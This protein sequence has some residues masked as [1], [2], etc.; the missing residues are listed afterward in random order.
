[1]G[2]ID[3]LPTQKKKLLILIAFC[4][5]FSIS[6]A[7]TLNR[8]DEIYFQSD[9]FARWYAASH[10]FQEGRNLYDFKNG[11]EVVQSKVRQTT[12]LEAAFYYPAYLALLLWPLTLLPFPTA[13]LLWTIAIG[14]FYFLGILI[15]ARSVEW[16]ANINR[17]T[18][19]ML[20]C[21]LFIPYLQ[22][23]IWSQFDTISIMFLALIFLALLREKYF[24]AGITAGGLL[25]K[26]QTM[27]LTLVFLLVWSLFSSKRRLFIAG[28][29]LVSIILWG[30]AQV[31]Q[32]GWVNEF[33]KALREYHQLPYR[34]ISVLDSL[35]NPK[36]L[37]SGL[38]LIAS[39]VIFLCF[40][41]VQPDSA[42]FGLCI[43]FSMS[44]WWLVVPVI[45]MMHLVLLPVVVILTLS[46]LWKLSLNAYRITQF[47]IL[48]L[49]LF[50]WVGF[51][52]GLSRPDL[53]GVHIQAA[54]LA[55]KVLCP[56]FL[57]SATI[58]GLILARKGEDQYACRQEDRCCHACL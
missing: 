26:P 11:E 51:I 41:K 57:L 40:R 32:P 7:F 22:N 48:S 20:L 5:L 8:S 3:L 52:Y 4:I 18:V 19:F 10:L 28:F 24:I 23:T 9:L 49:Y 25:F 54:E 29:V 50:S 46:S 34:V 21:V 1:M 37:L 13:H 2:S 55:I 58:Y 45:G 17:L 36:Q 42:V 27:V 47:G 44:V 14:L 31:V 6:L 30:A 39:L 15:F 56:I 12:P 33:I 43:A 35:W 38:L 53:Y 16:P